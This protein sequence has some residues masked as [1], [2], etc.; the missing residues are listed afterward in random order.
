MNSNK[1]KYFATYGYHLVGLISRCGIWEVSGSEIRIESNKKFASMVVIS[2]VSASGS[3]SE[4][5]FWQLR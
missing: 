1:T 5:I 2:K 3:L 4:K